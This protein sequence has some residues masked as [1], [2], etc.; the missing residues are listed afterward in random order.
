MHHNRLEMQCYTGYLTKWRQDR[1]KPP[2]T[3]MTSLSNITQEIKYKT[4]VPYLPDTNGMDIN[5]F[6]NNTLSDQYYLDTTHC[7]TRSK[8]YNCRCLYDTFAEYCTLDGKSVKD[9]LI[10]E[11][12][13][14]EGWYERA[15]SA[16]L[17]MRGITFK[18]WLI[19]L[20]KP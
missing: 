20:A 14:K 19:K 4:I 11:L 7:V 12:K 1:E 9:E 13:T 6:E 18:N 3:M 10:A 5:V 2:S 15:S 16:C 8:W 17:G